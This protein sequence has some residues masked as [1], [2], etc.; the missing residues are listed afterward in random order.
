MSLI[1]ACAAF[2]GYRASSCPYLGWKN[3]MNPTSTTAP[4]P[5]TSGVDAPTMNSV[6]IPINTSGKPTPI[7]GPAAHGDAFSGKK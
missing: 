6:N 2:G 7:A 3:S 1:F 4:A 5:S